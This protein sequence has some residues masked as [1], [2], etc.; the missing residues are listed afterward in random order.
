MAVR[1]AV[2][3]RLTLSTS[4][5]FVVAA[6]VPAGET[7]LIKSIYLYNAGAAAGPIVCDLRHPASGVVARVVDATFPTGTAPLQTVNAVADATCEL[8]IFSTVPPIHCW[9]SGSRLSG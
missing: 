8:R 7:W 1:S 2:L 9:W 6:T 3:A 5:T 4:G